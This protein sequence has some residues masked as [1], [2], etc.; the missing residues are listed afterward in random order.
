MS[1]AVAHKGCALQ[2]TELRGV[3]IK[4]EQYLHLLYAAANRDLEARILYE[5]VR[6]LLSWSLAGEYL[7]NPSIVHNGVPPVSFRR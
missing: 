7:R 3:P 1:P 4:A 2:D 6:T 5:E